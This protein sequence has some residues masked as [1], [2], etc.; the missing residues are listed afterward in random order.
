MRSLVV[1]AQR[2]VGLRTA[3]GRYVEYLAREWSRTTLPFD[4]VV[5]LAQESLDVEGLGGGTPVEL[6]CFG[7]RLPSI[8]WEQAALPARARRA[9]VLFC[10]AYTAPLAHAGPVVLANHGIY[11]RIPDEFPWFQ[12]LRS[13]PVHRLSARKADRVIAN[14]A[15]TRADLEAFFGIPGRKIDVV[16]PAAS[17]VFFE[18]KDPAAVRAQVC[19]TLGAEAP[20]FLFVGKFSKRRHVPNLIAAFAEVRRRLGL[21]HH[22]VLVGPNTSGIPLRRLCAEHGVERTVIHVAHLEQRAL[23]LLYAG[24]TAFVLPTTYEGIS[25]TMFEAMASETAVLTVDHP[26]VAEG[27]QGALIVPTPS[28]KDL[29]DGLERLVGDGELRAEIARRG[30]ERAAE[31]SWSAAA[32]ATIAILDNVARAADSA[33]GSRSSRRAAS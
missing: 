5:L 12:R 15:Q 4:R 8:A 32:R 21:A 10:P 22:L 29:A 30:R 26:T 7:R 23:A 2:M 6:E 17:D 33:P 28:T 1:N 24:A 31:F 14:S 16:Y 19:R 13:T 9:A 18:A 27:Q 20:Y 11:E 3:A 25:Y